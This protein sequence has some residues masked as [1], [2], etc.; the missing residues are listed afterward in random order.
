MGACSKDVI[1]RV[2]VINDYKWDGCSWKWNCSYASRCCY[3]LE[4][5]QFVLLSFTLSL[6]LLYGG[7]LS[8]AH[9]VRKESKKGISIFVALECKCLVLQRLFVNIEAAVWYVVY[10]WRRLGTLLCGWPW[11]NPQQY[12]LVFSLSVRQ[13]PPLLPLY[14][15]S[16]YSRCAL[17]FWGAKESLMVQ[18]RKIM[19]FGGKK[20]YLELTLYCKNISSGNV[21]KHV[22]CGST[23]IS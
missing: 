7:D 16:I 1:M 14:Q 15:C 20:H 10:L 3:S 21:K 6:F 12:L 11:V 13:H 4:L 19:E 22:W 17:H 2:K 9:S 23:Y 8:F 5:G 18:K